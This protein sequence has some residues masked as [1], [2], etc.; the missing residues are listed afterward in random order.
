LSPTLINIFKKEWQNLSDF[1]I[2]FI[3]E[4]CKLLQIKDVKFFKS[5]DLNLAGDKKNGELLVNM[6]NY[7]NCDHIIN[8]PKS[9]KYIDLELLKKNKIKFSIMSYENKLR[10]GK[11][12]FSIIDDIFNFGLNKNLYLKK[13][14]YLN[15]L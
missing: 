10:L 1:N 14:N 9:I 6:C 11:K 15:Y 8:G 4:I 5:S 7:L 13:D 2:F 12:N 3:R